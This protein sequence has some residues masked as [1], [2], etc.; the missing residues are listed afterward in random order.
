MVE[1]QT[2]TGHSYN[3]EATPAEGT[4]ARLAKLDRKRFPEI[5]TAGKEQDCYTNSTQ[6]PVEFTDDIFK[7]VELQDELQSLYTGG[8]VLHFYLGEK[9]ED[10]EICKK[11]IKKIFTTSKMPYISMTPTFSVCKNHGYVAG[12]H[13]N[14][15]HCGEKAEVWSRV[16]GYLRP[17]QDFND[18]KQD[19]YFTRKKYKISNC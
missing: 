8:T 9:I 18:S 13:F 15:P 6:L 14:C 5:I 16:V 17:V 19:E 10:K 11:L 12:E 2:E 1:Y 7:A 3:L 4:S